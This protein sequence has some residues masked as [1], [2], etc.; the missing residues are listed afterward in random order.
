MWDKP[1]ND[2][3]KLLKTNLYIL[4][5]ALIKYIEWSTSDNDY[6]NFWKEHIDSLCSQI[7]E[8]SLIID[9]KEVLLHTDIPQYR[10]YT[11]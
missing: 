1:E 7:E 11:T 2:I 9:I 4:K 6:E 8:V 3:K 10:I 5:S